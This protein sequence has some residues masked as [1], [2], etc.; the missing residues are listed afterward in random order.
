LLISPEQP[1]EKAIEA[2]Y[3]FAGGAPVMLVQRF[4][5]SR[6]DVRACLDNPTPDARLAA[7]DELLDRIGVP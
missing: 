5:L 1:R 2:L 4:E 3:L 7:L 6:A